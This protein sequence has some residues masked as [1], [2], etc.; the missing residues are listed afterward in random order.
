MRNLFLCPSVDKLFGFCA[1]ECNGR[2]GLLE[3]RILSYTG[4]G[5]SSA[6][7]HQEDEDES[8]AVKI[9]T[10]KLECS[11]LSGDYCGGYTKQVC[12]PRG[13]SQLTRVAQEVIR[14]SA[15]RAAQ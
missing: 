11:N 14:S 13:L 3:S 12:R 15:Y 5:S 6:A 8:F 10:N 7:V 1:H 4:N 2:F 9:K